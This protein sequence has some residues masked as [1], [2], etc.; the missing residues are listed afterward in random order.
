MTLIVKMTS[1]QY[2]ENSLIS[3]LL[4]IKYL[5]VLLILYFFTLMKIVLHY[6][7]IEYFGPRLSHFYNFTPT[8]I[9]TPK[10]I[11]KMMI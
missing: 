9:L 11:C 8:F 1:T 3:H 2:I 5:I 7:K 4:I 6:F 10:K